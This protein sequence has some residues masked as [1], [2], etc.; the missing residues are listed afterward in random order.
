[1]TRSIRKA[2]LP[3]LAG[4]LIAASPAAAANFDAATLAE[5]CAGCHGT[6]GTSLGAAPTIANLTVE[7]FVLS[8][9]DYASGARASTVMGRIAK[10]YSE[11]EIKAMAAYFDKK[12]FGR[13]VQAFDTALID[14]GKALQAKY[15]ES[16]HEK[17]GRKSDGIGV[18]AGQRL[19]YMA[20]SIEDFK[21]G[22]RVLER[23]KKQKMDELW[24]D[25]GDAGY[26]AVLH[27]YASHSK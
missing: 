17:D 18:L 2:L 19:P 27:Y 13:T 7:Y 12:P 24:A 4:L 26:D 1:M 23:R 6:D 25:Q 11:D 8:M 14:K 9:K 22:R 15:C 3:S 16:C 20:Y 5:T 10:G 21:D